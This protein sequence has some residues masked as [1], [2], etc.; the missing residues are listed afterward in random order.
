M[1]TIA[2]SLFCIFA[3]LASAAEFRYRATVAHVMD[4]DTVG[5]DI[6][7][8]L[9]VSKRETVRLVGIDTPERKAGDPWRKAADFTSKTLIRQPPEEAVEVIILTDNDKRDKYGRRLVTL[10]VEG[11]NFNKLLVKKGHAKPWDGRGAHP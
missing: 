1:K 5:L 2:I 10:Y 4:G 3:S 9:D 6:S 11:V 8:G 7:L